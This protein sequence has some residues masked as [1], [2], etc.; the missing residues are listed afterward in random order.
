MGM[1]YGRIF[2]SFYHIVYS[3]KFASIY[4]KGEFE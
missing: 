4:S 1:G 2:C 3:G